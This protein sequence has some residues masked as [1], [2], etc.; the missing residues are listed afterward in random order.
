MR[1]TDRAGTG[2]MRTVN[3][4]DAETN[5]P[6]LVEQAALGEP[7]IIAKDGRPLVRVQPIDAPTSVETSRIG[8]LAGRIHVPDDFDQMGRD[9]IA[10][11]FEDR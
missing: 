7:F 6:H 10:A 2:S 3:L 5:L 8:F 9:D 1:R 4:K 11:S